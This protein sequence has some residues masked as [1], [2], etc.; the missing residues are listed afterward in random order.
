M[1]QR[2]RARARVRNPVLLLSAVTWLMLGF[3]PGGLLPVEHCGVAGFGAS[4]ASFQLALRLNPP[5]SLAAGWALMLAAMMLPTLIE[6]IYHVTERSL[7]RRRLRSVVLFV[8]GYAG[9]WMAAGAVLLAAQLALSVLAPQSYLP[10]AV[11]GLVAFVWQCSPLKQICL[12]RGHNHHELAAFGFAADWAALRFGLVH[13][14]WCFGS[15]WALMLFPMLLPQG[16]FV[17]MAA[18]TCLMISERL[19]Q[20]ARLSWRLRGPGRLIRLVVAQARLR[21]ETWRSG[22]GSSPSAA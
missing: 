11:V 19:E 16:H 12:N 17:V 8:L 4:S 3:N 5:A 22:S 10:A 15:C 20:P 2:D 6:P 14:V 18:M 9:T 7:K 21:L 13:G 1:T